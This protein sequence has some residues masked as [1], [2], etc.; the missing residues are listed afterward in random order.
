MQ[1]FAVVLVLLA[2][3]HIL[4]AAQALRVAARKRKWA[5]SKL[6]FARFTAVVIPLLGPL[7]IFIAL[8]PASRGDPNLQNNIEVLHERP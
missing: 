3:L 5:G 4:L 8:A 7:L 6:S 1:T 2:L